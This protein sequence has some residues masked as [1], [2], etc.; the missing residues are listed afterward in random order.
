V[1]QWL[2]DFFDRIL[3]AVANRK[4]ADRIL[5][6][7]SWLKLS[8]LMTLMGL[9][10]AGCQQPVTG[11]G[12]GP[13]ITP[14]KTISV[15]QLAGNLGLRVADVADT[16]VMLKDSANTVLIF[17]Y[18]GGQVYVNTRAIGE[19]GRVDRIGDSV[20]VSE[21]LE[22]LIRGQMQRTV[23]PSVKPE[24]PGRLSGLVV[25][26]AGHGGQDPG[27]TSRTGYYEKAVNLQVA[28]K[29]A[30]LLRQKGL[31]VVM[32]RDS[33]EFI[34][35]EE[36]AAI[37]N[38]NNANLFVSIHCDSMENSSKRG[39][40]IYI[41]RSSSWEARRAATAIAREMA[42]TGIDNQG[43]RQADY[44]V[45][46]YTEGPAVL[47]EL[48]YLSNYQEAGLLRDNSFQNRLAEAIANG[49]VGFLG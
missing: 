36:R 26:D 38:R 32:T 46:I 15:Y 34:E 13:L 45:L 9:A 43:I 30:T 41:A 48:G 5:Q 21:S 2:T 33:D 11:P 20:Y 10:I 49:V 7:R 16:H 23:R 8:I 35:L 12:E 40:T 31:R 28:R 37:A 29:V 24:F 47:V 42:K 3:K 22:G 1:N 18:S 4:T 27:A 25:I 14:Q 19:T 39:F 44:K 17:T 6:M